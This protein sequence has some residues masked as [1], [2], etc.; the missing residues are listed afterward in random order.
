MISM[1]VISGAKHKS[2]QYLDISGRKRL[3]DD[4]S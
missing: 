4:E 1:S 3:D 2:S